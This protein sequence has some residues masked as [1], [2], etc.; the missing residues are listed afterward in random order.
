MIK[1]FKIFE[2]INQGEPKIGDYVIVNDNTDNCEELKMFVGKIFTIDKFNHNLYPYII[3]YDNLPEKLK[4]D[5][6]IWSAYE[7][8]KL[9]NSRIFS[10]KEIKCWSKDKEELQKYIDAEKFGL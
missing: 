5:N 10:R 8:Y 2:S 7:E 4:K 1:N 6:N 3:Y 9:L